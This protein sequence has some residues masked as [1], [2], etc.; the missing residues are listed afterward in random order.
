MNDHVTQY[1]VVGSIPRRSDRKWWRGD[2]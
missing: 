1:L 2:S